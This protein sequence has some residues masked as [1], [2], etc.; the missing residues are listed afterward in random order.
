M[1]GRAVHPPLGDRKVRDK[2]L[3]LPLVGL[4]LLMPPVAGIVPL[5]LGVGGV[6]L[7]LAYVF[8]VWAGLIAGAATLSRRLGADDDASAPAEAR[9]D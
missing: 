9:K 2:A 4:I 7:T 6:T 1:P 3:A 8:L 5:D